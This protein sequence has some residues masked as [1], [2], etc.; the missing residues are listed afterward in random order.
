LSLPVLS[1]SLATALWCS[2]PA[3]AQTPLP[4]LEDPALQACLDEEVAARSW[5]FAEDVR[6]L[7]CV[8]R[9]VLRLDG[10]SGLIALTELDVSDN[11][12]DEVWPLQ[13]FWGLTHLHLSGNADL[14]PSEVLSVVAFNGGLTHLGLN[15]IPLENLWQLPPLPLVE[16][17]VSNTGIRDVLHL[18]NY[19]AL[20]AL[21][22]SDNPISNDSL[23][24]LTFLNDLQKL[25]L[26]GTAITDV[27]PLSG[28]RT[29]THLDVSG[30]PVDELSLGG[31]EF[32]VSMN[33][34]L[35]HLGLADLPIHDLI[36]IPLRDNDTWSPL[37]LV[38]L[39]LSG[40]DIDD[41]WQLTQHPELETLRLARN[42]ISDIA[43][44]AQLPALQT[45]ILQGNQ[46]TDVAALQALHSL[47]EL[48]LSDN[49][50]GSL[51]AES[52][53]TTLT[54]LDLSRNAGL[55]SEEP[56]PIL[57]INQRLT[58]LALA[59]LPIQD[60]SALPLWLH[61]MAL[62]E[63]DL[64][65]TQI[66]GL[67]SLYLPEI[68]VLR[69]ANN[70]ISD[71]AELGGFGNPRELDVS[72]NALTSLSPLA[73]PVDSRL[74]RLDVSGNSGV[75]QQS[76]AFTV[77]GHR[78]LT[79][80][81]LRDI[82]IG[83]LFPLFVGPL[84][85]PARPILELDLGN[86]SIDSLD[87]FGLSE[88]T[89]LRVLKLDGNQ[90]WSMG[91]L[92]SLVRL[93]ALDLSD[94]LIDDLSSL[95][96]LLDDDRSRIL[97]LDL[98]NNSIS[99]LW[100]LLLQTSLQNLNLA[101]NQITDIEPLFGG[102]QFRSVSLLGNEG[103][104][105]EELDALELALGPGVL[106]RPTSCA[107]SNQPPVAQTAPLQTVELGLPSVLDGTASWDP[108]GDD[109]TFLWTD[110]QGV[111][112][113]E[114]AVVVLPLGLGS[115]DFTLT[116]RDA[117]GATSQA[118]ARVVVHDSIAPAVAVTAPV[119]TAILQGMPAAIEWTASDA[120]DVASS[121]VFF[122]SDGGANFSPIVGCTGLSGAARSCIWPAPGPHTGT[123]VI[124]VEVRDGS[125][126]M[127]MAETPVVILSNELSATKDS[128]VIE[129][130][131]N[132]N[133]GANPKLV[134]DSDRTLL[135]FSLADLT[136]AMIQEVELV[137][138][139][140]EPAKEWGSTGRN[141]AVHRVLGAFEEGDGKKFEVPNAQKTSGSGPGA[142]WN[143]A[144]DA[145][146]SN[147][148]PDC[149][150]TWSGGATLI[151]GLSDVAL[152]TVDMTGAVAWS[153]TAD[154]LA[155]LADGET[156]VRFLLKRELESAGGHAEYHSREG[157]ELAGNP[158]L[159]PRLRLNP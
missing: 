150:T 73:V 57:A 153:V 32:F 6:S 97:D 140:A 103:A 8:D 22:L 88:L 118:P 17:N 60:V 47:T 144:I 138:T 46:I 101:D 79:H 20:R 139:L 28:I 108:D 4:Q 114:S 68:E 115:H 145:E 94:N 151:G 156:V 21:D 136:P 127:G 42:R 29:L 19:P 130:I 152:H 48:D 49:V 135:E 134:V 30:I 93:R 124:R 18:A 25:D 92:A 27:L 117:P 36:R 10:I 16:L 147:N 78:R 66:S 102:F 80:L 104:G 53:F 154:V 85:D 61:Q 110:S 56:F 105:C 54:R 74:E 33:A 148:A 34:G 1:I 64:S 87:L 82:P 50:L 58:H 72:G 99:D 65:D 2:T 3:P 35:T 5:Q 95:F 123:G 59:G 120:G 126:N 55:T 142:T 45:L 67:G 157:A 40:T 155:A 129:G 112:V 98:Q 43:A 141:V 69:V 12:L 23:I 52:G 41:I 77:Q 109:L 96:P 11:L 125:G 81:G 84:G 62:V 133:E 14:D 15:D 13:A 137:L 100:P 159:A 51:P 122:S 143:C 26:S 76:L 121:D 63:L 9:G 38:E 31:V 107:A 91:P 116:V 90:I 146:I 158:G 131:K 119:A 83:D 71:L 128:F 70:Q 113:G 7:T 89:R 44:L 132:R 106:T 111:N 39:D 75:D 24:S 86:T 149:L 37:R